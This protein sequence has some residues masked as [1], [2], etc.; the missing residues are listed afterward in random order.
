[1][2]IPRLVALPMAEK[3]VIGVEITNAQGQA[4]KRIVRLWANHGVNG[5]ERNTT[6]ITVSKAATTKTPGV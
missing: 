5:W 3:I 4:I 2:R 6:G 1:M